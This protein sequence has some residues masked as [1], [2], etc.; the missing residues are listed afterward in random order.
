MGLFRTLGI[1]NEPGFP[2]AAIAAVPLA[3]IGALAV[4]CFVKL[5]GAVFLGS[6]RREATRTLMTRR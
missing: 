2:I 1:G 6:P 4:A 5:F 3:M